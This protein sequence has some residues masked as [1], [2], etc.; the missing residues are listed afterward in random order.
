MQTGAV[1]GGLESPHLLREVFFIPVTSCELPVTNSYHTMPN[2]KKIDLVQQLRE[3][4]SYAKGVVFTDYTGLSVPE[5]QELRSKL[6]EQEADYTVAKNTLA[7]RA[8]KEQLSQEVAL[9]G[10]TALL[11]SYKDPLSSIKALFEYIKENKIPTVKSG[12]F[13]GDLLDAAGITELSEIPSREE[14]LGKFIGTLNAPIANFV[15]ILQANLR[16]FLST[17]INIK[18][19]KGNGNP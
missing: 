9:E 12:I 5:I 13:E 6:Q 17:L 18:G 8:L 7:K 19:V 10:P 11:I 2:Q 3:K 4:L 16:E 15:G 14:L 1:R